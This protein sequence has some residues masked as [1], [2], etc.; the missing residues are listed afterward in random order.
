METTNGRTL[1]EEL[2]EVI[3]EN[4][5][6]IALKLNEETSKRACDICKDELEEDD[7]VMGVELQLSIKS[8]MTSETKLKMIIAA[9][10][11]LDGYAKS[12]TFETLKEE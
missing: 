7:E 9:L 6:L 11:K 3:K 1:L 12:I 8:L 10:S 5:Y 2:E 4:G